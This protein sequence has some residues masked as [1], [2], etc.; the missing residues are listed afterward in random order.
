[1]KPGLAY[2]LFII[3]TTGPLGDRQ[4]ITRV[5]TDGKY[6]AMERCEWLKRQILETTP[7]IKRATCIEVSI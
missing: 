1:M 3:I 6:T 7:H 4:Q 2:A 5:N